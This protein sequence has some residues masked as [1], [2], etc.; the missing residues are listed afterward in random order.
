MPHVIT[1]TRASTTSVATALAASVDRG[2]TGTSS[3][4]GGGHLTT[5]CELLSY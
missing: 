2:R 1:A 5:T 3:Q 4:G